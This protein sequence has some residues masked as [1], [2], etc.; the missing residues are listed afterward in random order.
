MF[1]NVGWT[2]II[3]V[4]KYDNYFRRGRYLFDNNDDR[5]KTLGDSKPKHY[6]VYMYT[7]NKVESHKATMSNICV[8]YK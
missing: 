6:R 3:F 8:Y 4:L 2:L 7:E 1:R 5:A